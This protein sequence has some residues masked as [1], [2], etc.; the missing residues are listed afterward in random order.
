MTARVL[1]NVYVQAPAVHGV[2]P[3]SVPAPVTTTETVAMSPVAVP[4]APPTLVAAVFVSSGNVRTVPLTDVRVTA[5]PVVSTV[6]DFA[7]EVPTLVAVSLWVAVS[8]YTPVA[9]SATAGVNVHRPVEQSALPFCVLA[10]VMATVTVALSPAAFVQV[11]P[12]LVTVVFVESGNVRALPFTVVNETV[13]ATVSTE[14]AFA[15]LSP[16]LPAE[17]DCVASTV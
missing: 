17:S 5:G 10:P 1:T 6:I 15:P 2:V 9:D 14:I 7:P 16:T 4:H 12:T 8:E 3:L 11:P 13:G